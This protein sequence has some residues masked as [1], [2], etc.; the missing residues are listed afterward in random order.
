MEIAMSAEPD[1]PRTPGTTSPRRPTLQDIAAEAGVSK[2]LT[3]MILSGTPGPSAATTARVQEIATRLGY[4]KSKAAT[5]LANRRSRLLGVTVIPTSQFHGE[6][7][8]EIQDVAD[9]LGYEIVLGAINRSHDERRTVETLVD[10]HCE[11][12]LLLGLTLPAAK[13]GQL[14]AGLPAVSVGRRI[15]HP[16]IDVVRADDGLAVARL[17]EHLVTFGHHRIVHLDGG[18]GAISDLRRRSFRTAMRRHGLTP[19]VVDGGLTERHGEAAVT[20][21]LAG[22]ELPSAIVCFNDRTAFG[23]IGRLEQ[24]GLTVP[25]EISVTGYDDSTIARHPRIGLTTVDQSTTEQA[26]LAVQVAVERLAGETTGRREIVL[27]PRL[28][29]RGSTGPPR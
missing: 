17:V 20:S 14:V 24:L 4:R 29:V 23:A 27:E 28:I 10:F 18:P 7:A 2:G 21:V 8:E 16:G 6:L 19:V 15:D 11:A 5:L 26:R 25:G 13:V 22:H 12:L 9:G 1:G 3:S